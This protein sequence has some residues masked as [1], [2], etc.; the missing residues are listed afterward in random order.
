MAAHSW[1][2]VFKYTVVLQIP[3]CSTHR[4]SNERVALEEGRYVQC[5]TRE[6]GATCCDPHT[7]G[8]LTNLFMNAVIVKDTIDVSSAIIRG[9]LSG[10]RNRILT[11]Q[12]QSLTDATVH[13]EP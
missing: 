2:L 10:R 8:Q 7:L 1:D 11:L 5:V 12:S 9:T 4:W 3:Q 6:L 13:L